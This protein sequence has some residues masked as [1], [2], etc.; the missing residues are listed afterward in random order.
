MV[1]VRFYDTK[2]SVNQKDLSSK[3]VSIFLPRKDDII[4]QLGHSYSK[5]PLCV[6][7]LI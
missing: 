2:S 4:T 7:R 3:H 5:D 1:P 6:T